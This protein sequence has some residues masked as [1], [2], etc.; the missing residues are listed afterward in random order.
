GAGAPVAPAGQSLFRGGDSDNHTAADWTLGP[1]PSPRS[2]QNTGLTVPLLPRFAPLAGSPTG[3]VNLV[4]GV[5]TGTFTVRDTA[6]VG[7]L[8]ASAV[9]LPL[10]R[11]NTFAVR[12]PTKNTP[13]TFTKGGDQSISE[14]APAQTLA[15]WATGISPGATSEIGSQTVSFVVT[16]DNPGLFAAGPAVASDGALTFNPAPNANGF[17]N[18]TVQAKDDGG[19]AG[20]GQDTSAAQTFIITVLPVNDAPTITVA[21]DISRPQNAGPQV[22]PNWATGIGPGAPNEASQAVVLEVTAANPSFFIAGPSLAEDGTLTFTL[23]SD[24]S[25][26]TNVVVTV[27][28]DGGTANGGID[29]TQRTITVTSRIVNLAPSFTKGPD[30]VVPDRVAFSQ[31]WATNVSPGSASESNQTVRFTVTTDRPDLFKTQPGITALGQLSFLG[32]KGGGTATVTVSLSD[33][34]GTADGGIDLS[35]PETFTIELTSVE[36]A[37]G[38]YRGLVQAPEGV[39]ATH[40]RSG[41]LE[42]KITKKGRFS[43]KLYLGGG[44]HRLRGELGDNGVAIFKGSAVLPIQR[45]GLPPVQLSFSAEVID[46]RPHAI[47]GTILESGN[48]LAEFTANA[49]AYSRDNPVPGSLVTSANKGN[50]TGVF[51]AHPTPNGGLEADQFPLG[52]GWTTVKVKST[53]T[54]KMRGRFA[55]GSKFSYSAALDSANGFPIYLPLYRGGGAVAGQASFDTSA[56]EIHLGSAGLDWFCP[57]QGSP[58]YPAGWMNGIL[59]GFDGASRNVATEPNALPVGPATLTLTGGDLPAEGFMKPLVIG[60]KNRLSAATSGADKLKLKLKPNGALSGS[61]I[62]P[63]TGKKTK[64]EGVTLR[65]PIEARG[66]FLG[67]SASGQVSIQP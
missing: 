34:G 66:F 23:S 59:L 9:S 62:D 41:R 16:T 58:T 53:G 33:N 7:E 26:S 38:K 67:P 30:L 3:T 39:L 60:A 49:D 22:I 37:T 54:L 46:S 44:S 52:D 36:N 2:V 50:F 4:N 55:D 15:G 11:S 10:A 28:D 61:F 12:A 45:K 57:P 56:A 13:P 64:L 31:P 6:T 20:G 48:P 25:G 27:M 40:A 65:D 8:Q 18:V 14:D 19:T 21:G 47:T 17:A 63:V 42:V 29:T 51:P 43:G 5:W 1:T 24:V 35:A 32:G